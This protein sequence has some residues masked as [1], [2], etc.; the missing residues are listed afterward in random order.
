[1]TVPSEGLEVEEEVEEDNRPRSNKKMPDSK[2]QVEIHNL[3]AQRLFALGLLVVP[4]E[5][6]LELELELDLELG[7]GSG[8]EPP[9][10]KRLYTRSE[11]SPP[12][13]LVTKLRNPKMAA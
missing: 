4:L 2:Q 13:G 7:E 8:N 1:M 3:R 12:A 10:P 6:E 11:M 5:L 9:P